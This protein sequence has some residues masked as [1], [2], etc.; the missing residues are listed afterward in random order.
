LLREGFFADLTI[1]DPATII[2]KAT[3]ADPAQLSEGV[4]YVLVNGQL[5]FDNG[6]LTGANAGRALKGPGAR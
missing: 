3:Y 5:T 2:D 6:K 1:F 4:K